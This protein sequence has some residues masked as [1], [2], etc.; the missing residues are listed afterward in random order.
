MNQ[1]LK[2]KVYMGLESRSKP[3][4]QN[5]KIRYNCSSVDTK[6]TRTTSPLYYSKGGNS[7]Y[8]SKHLNLNKFTAKGFCLT[9]YFLWYPCF[10]SDPTC[11]NCSLPWKFISNQSGYE[12]MTHWTLISSLLYPHIPRTV[13]WPPKNNNPF[14]TWS[15]FFTATS[16]SFK[17][18]LSPSQVF[19]LDK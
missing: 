18:S 2:I 1:I 4:I 7:A 17:L 13:F 8:T 5:K 9:E 3:N 16:Q 14:L 6:N 12:E 19:P 15:L 11:Q 10:L